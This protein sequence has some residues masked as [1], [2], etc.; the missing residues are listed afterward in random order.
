MKKKML[1]IIL[2]LPVLFSL[3]SCSAKPYPFQAQIDEIESIEIVSAESCLEYTVVKVLS[4]AEKDR[5]LKQFNEIKFRDYYMGDPM[6]VHGDTIKITYRSGVYE[7]IC[8]FWSE[9]VENGDIYFVSKYCDEKA[10]N[11]LLNNFL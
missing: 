8:F 3:T 1:F 11:N 6:S 9:Y 2:F 7:M 4:E 5:F 10:F